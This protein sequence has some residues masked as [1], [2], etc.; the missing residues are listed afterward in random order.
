MFGLDVKEKKRK[1]KMTMLTREQ[2]WSP[3][4]IEV[5][6][7]TLVGGCI[8][9]S[10]PQH[11]GVVVVFRELSGD[12]IKQLQAALPAFKMSAKVIQGFDNPELPF[13]PSFI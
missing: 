2:E 13:V 4:A 11:P 5:I 1:A 7:R 12:E 6:Q 10:H 3:S 9:S 8:I